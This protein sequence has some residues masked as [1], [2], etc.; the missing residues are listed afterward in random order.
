MKTAEAKSDALTMKL[1]K[2]EAEAKTEIAELTLK[3]QKAE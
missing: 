1:K 2:A 3:L